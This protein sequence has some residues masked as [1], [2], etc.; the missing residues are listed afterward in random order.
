MLVSGSQASVCK[1]PTTQ[2]MGYLYSS[3]F[4]NLFIY[5]SEE[6]VSRNII[7]QKWATDSNLEKGQKVLC[8]FNLSDVIPPAQRCY[9]G[10]T[11]SRSGRN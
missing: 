9:E 6:S 2:T 11:A 7:F 5:P 8:T 10:I 3:T 1:M 4:S